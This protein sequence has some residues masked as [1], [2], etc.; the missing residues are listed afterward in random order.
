MACFRAGT[1][2]GV[3]C[4]PVY[5]WCCHR[6]WDCWHV[7]NFSLVLKLRHQFASL[8]G[9]FQYQLR[10]IPCDSKRNHPTGSLKSW[11]KSRKSRGVEKSLALRSIYR[12]WI[13]WLWW[14][15]Q[16]RYSLD[17][18]FGTRISWRNQ[19]RK[20]WHHPRVGRNK[21][22]W[23]CLLKRARP[24]RPTKSRVNGGGQGKQGEIQ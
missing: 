20:P 23:C 11:W 12:S 16:H 7:C 5:D 17:A 22:L 24:S 1:N 21:R 19:D 15:S 13:I 3:F 10:S 2:P 14:I 18:R 8:L 6:L 9:N 4:V